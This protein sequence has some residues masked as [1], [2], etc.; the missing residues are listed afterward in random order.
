MQYLQFNALHHSCSPY[1]KI[2]KE[3]EEEMETVIHLFFTNSL[4]AMRI[5]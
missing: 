4:Q 3:T 5:H 2:V 1:F